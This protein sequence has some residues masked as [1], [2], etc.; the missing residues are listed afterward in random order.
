MINELFIE[1]L[2]LLFVLIANHNTTPTPMDGEYVENHLEI[3]FIDIRPSV[4]H[5]IAHWQS[6]SSE[7]AFSAESQ[8]PDSS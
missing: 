7:F 5:S 4:T 6:S 1:G 8:P 3:I 2:I